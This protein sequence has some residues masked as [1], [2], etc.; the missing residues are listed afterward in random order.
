MSAIIQAVKKNLDITQNKPLKISLYEA[1]R[2]T[3]ILGEI[4]CSTRIKRE[5]ILD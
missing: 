4:P 5:R 3:I 1:F 2:K